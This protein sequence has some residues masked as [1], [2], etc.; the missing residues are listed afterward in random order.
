[1]GNIP[2]LTSI[3]F[4]AALIVFLHHYLLLSDTVLDGAT[5]VASRH[6][7]ENP[8]DSILYVLMY[9]GRYGVSLFFVLSGFL[10]TARYYETIHRKI[11]FKTYWIKRFARIMPLYWTICAAT[12]V[13]AFT[14]GR[15]LEH[16]L[17]YFTLTQSFFSDLMFHG[18]ETAWSLTVEETFYLSL[19]LLIIL[20]RAV[21]KDR[22]SIWTN[23]VAISV[24]LVILT[25]VYWQ[26]GMLLHGLNKNGTITLWGFMGKIGEIRAYTI[27]GRFFDFAAGCVLGMVYYKSRNPLLEKRWLPDL[28]IAL[29]LVGILV[30]SYHIHFLGGPEGRLGWWLLMINAFLSAAIIYFVCSNKSVIARVLSWRPFVY[31]GLISYSFYLVHKIV[32]TNWMYRWCAQNDVPFLVATISLYAIITLLAAAGYEL[33][34]RP[35]QALILR[36]TGV[37]REIKNPPLALRLLSR[38]LAR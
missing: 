17:V 32:F 7:G 36:Q 23:A 1:M 33:I 4:L 22:R 27:F 21:W 25:G 38:F 28:S 11:G 24:L 10:L 9:E 5:F 13:Y 6:F 20:F 2:A 16:Y 3:R 18:V 35:C 19:P 14:R 30:T 29:A 8:R 15:D 37:I 26:A 34:E 12:F 31:L